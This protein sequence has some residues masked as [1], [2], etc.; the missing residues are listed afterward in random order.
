ME[1]QTQTAIPL[2]LRVWHETSKLFPWARDPG[3]YV[4]GVQ[5]PMAVGMKG[6]VFSAALK[7]WPCIGTTVSVAELIEACCI[8]CQVRII[9]LSVLLVV[10]SVFKP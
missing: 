3:I 1:N 10:L 6:L 4:I 8:S 9:L 5:A 7:P 2:E